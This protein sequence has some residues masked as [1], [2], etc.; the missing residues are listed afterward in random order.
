MSSNGNLPVIPALV[1]S[2]AGVP[3][4]RH[5]V[6]IRRAEAH[7]R[8]LCNLLAEMN[9]QVAAVGV[10]AVTPCL[11]GLIANKISLVDGAIDDLENRTSGTGKAQVEERLLV[12]KRQFK[13]LRETLEM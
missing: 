11:F 8:S 4:R 9:A 10:S 2:F 5:L 1:P 13:A 6:V 7:F 12:L 3:S